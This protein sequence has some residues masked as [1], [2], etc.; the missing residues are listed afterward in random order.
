MESTDSPDTEVQL[1]AQG[2]LAAGAR[3]PGTGLG[4]SR[5]RAG[6]RLSLLLGRSP[7]RGPVLWFCLGLS[8]T[9][10]AFKRLFVQLIAFVCSHLFSKLS[11]PTGAPASFWNHFPS[12]ED[13]SGVSCSFFLFVSDAICT[14]TEF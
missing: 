13:S 10:K 4:G 11:I 1:G 3:E 12:P 5:G 7:R 9:G 2:Q 14:D 8:Y 6:M